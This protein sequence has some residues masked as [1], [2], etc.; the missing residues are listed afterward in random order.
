MMD[1]KTTPGRCEVIYAPRRPKAFTY[2][3]SIFLAGTIARTGPDW[4]MTLT[5][6]LGGNEVTILNPHREDWDSSWREEVSFSPWKE[7]V[8]WEKDMREC[9]D[10][11]VFFFHP[12]SKAPITLGEFGASSVHVRQGQTVI[13][14]CPDGFWQK[15]WVQLMCKLEHIKFVES[16]QALIEAVQME[17]WKRSSEEGRKG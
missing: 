10:I 4:R 13:V 1:L 8:Q 5:A 15:G 14:G 7:Q 6:T 2:S 17:M 11:A 3:T 9:A 12:D 16:E